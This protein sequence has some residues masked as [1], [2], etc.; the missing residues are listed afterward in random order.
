M[1]EGAWDPEQYAKFRDERSAPF[2]DLVS[3]L[4]P[5]EAPR[6]VDLG[7]G[8]GELTRA[9]HERIGARATRGIDTS[10][11]MLAKA[12][13]DVPGLSFARGD[14]ATF[15]GTGEWDVVLSNAAVQWVPDHDALFARL[16]ALLA[17][18]GQLAVQMPAN[19]DHASHEIA[20]AVAR[21][22]PF[23]SALGGF[24]MQYDVRMPEEYATMLFRLGVAQQHVRLQVYA[25]V[26]ASRDDVVEWVKGTHLTAYRDRLPADVFARFLERYQERLFEVLPDEHPFFY[27]FKRLLL[28]ARRS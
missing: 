23:A 5:V 17:P 28:W 21:E 26:L 4:A 3:L 19:Q 6:V 14:L 27:P 1:T 12:P 16:I 25:H 15:E 8:S 2:W 13:R 20:R 18:G 9:L 7:C 11:A 22:E 24:V 10:E